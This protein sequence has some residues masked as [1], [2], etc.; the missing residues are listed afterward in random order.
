MT[1]NF[2]LV[3]IHSDRSFYEKTLDLQYL[4]KRF[5]KKKKN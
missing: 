3:S 5:L 2:F 1:N 4:Q